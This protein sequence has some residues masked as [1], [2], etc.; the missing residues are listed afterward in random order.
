MRKVFVY[1][2]PISSPSIEVSTD[3]IESEKVWRPCR[4]GQNLPL[5]ERIQPENLFP[6]T[7]VQWTPTAAETSD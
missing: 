3:S 4:F 6:F 5:S 1:Q 7:P 2:S